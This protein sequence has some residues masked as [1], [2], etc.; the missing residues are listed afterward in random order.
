MRSVDGT[1][2]QDAM[3]RERVSTH[4]VIRPLEPEEELP[5]LKLPVELIGVVSELAM[6]RYQDGVEF[7]SRKFSKARTAIAKARRKNLDRAKRDTMHTMAQ[8]QS[9]LSQEEHDGADEPEK[10]KDKAKDNKSKRS[11]YH[12]VKE[13]LAT[14]NWSWA[15]ALD[16][17]ERP[18]PSSIVARRDTEEA[19]QLAKI[20]DQAVMA[21]EHALSAN[22]FWS[23]IV[24]FLTLTPDK[25]KHGHG[26]DHARDRDHSPEDGERGKEKEETHSHRSL[27]SRLVPERR[28]DHR[29]EQKTP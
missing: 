13:G 5:A 20:A 2:I 3:I 8:L 27:L 25:H 26:S 12:G 14:G 15:W 22:N 1:S 16:M 10:A 17:D 9:S 23:L 7:F 4:G 21:D 24:D 28:K 6:R 11:T 19:R 29:K 18:P